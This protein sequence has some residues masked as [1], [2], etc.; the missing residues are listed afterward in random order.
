MDTGSVAGF[1]GHISFLETSPGNAASDRRRQSDA[2]T[3]YSTP[4]GF[5]G[6]PDAYKTRAQSTNSMRVK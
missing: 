5:P 4:I 6:M 2:L 3:F 1:P